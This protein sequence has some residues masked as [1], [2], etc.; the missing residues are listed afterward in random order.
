MPSRRSR[1]LTFSRD[2]QEGGILTRAGE[3][4]SSGCWNVLE[5]HKDN[6]RGSENGEL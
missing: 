2:V 6:H 4:P 1:V 3:E 5:R